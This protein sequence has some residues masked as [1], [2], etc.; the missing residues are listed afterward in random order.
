MTENLLFKMMTLARERHAQQLRKYTGDPYVIHCGEVAA[1]AMSA[2][3]GQSNWLCYVGCLGWGHDLIEDTDTTHKELTLMFGSTIADGILM[4]SDLEEGN[5]KERKEAARIRLSHAPPSVQSVKVADLISNTSSIVK[6][7]IDFARVY[8]KE[9]QA[10]LGVLTKAH[11]DLRAIAQAQID[12]SLK[13][14]EMSDSILKNE[15]A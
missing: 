1:L 10:M 14:I 12:E 11:P 5:R 6:H 3:G 15:K 2:Y 8:I 7:D 9:K 13:I 4:L